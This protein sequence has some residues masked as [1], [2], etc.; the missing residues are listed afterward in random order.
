MATALYI[1]STETYSG[2]TALAVGIA[3]RMR[4]DGLRVGYFKPLSFS[5]A[6]EEQGPVDE[7]SRVIK[8]LL[9]LKEPLD[10]LCPV[11][12]TPTVLDQ[13]VRG[14][15]PDLADRIMSAYD[16]VSADK[17]VVIIEGANNMATG[18]MIDMSGIEIVAAFK[19]KCVVVVRYRYD[20]VIDHLLIARRVVGEAVVGS[21]INT[22]PPSRLEWVQKSV[23][24]FCEKRG[25]KILAALPED[26]L[27]MASTVEEIAAALNGEILCAHDKTDALVEN[28][29]VGGMGAETALQ[30]FRRKANKAVIAGGDR[31]DLLS[32]ALETSTA[33]LIL[34]GNLHPGAQILSRA[35]DQGVPVIMSRH[36]TMTTVQI[37]DRTLG[38]V[39]FHDPKKMLRFDSMLDERFDYP[40]L[41][42]ELGIKI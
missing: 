12:I 20:L 5:A 40:G 1:T 34:S 25:I 42:A 19:A 4:H 17:D 26:R 29:M 13:I 21:V 37:V 22:I 6:R 7:D 32:A 27:L 11:L 35:E 9:G 14:D 38:K 16:N 36:D 33:C 39:R 31:T 23:K 2:K 28:I 24:P 15:K 10:V 41:Y 30:Y 8:R 3:Q 18:C